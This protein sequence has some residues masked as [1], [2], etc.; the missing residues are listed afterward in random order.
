MSENRPQKKW[1]FAGVA[2]GLLF[3]WLALRQAD[4]ATAINELSNVHPGWVA[5]VAAC[6]MIFIAI[7]ALRWQY[8]LHPVTH[9]SFNTLHKVIYIGTAAN[10]VVAHTGEL[11][12][13]TII[14]RRQDVSSS[15]VLTSIGLERIMD[16][17]ALLILTSIALIIDP[18]VSPILWSAGLISLAMIVVGLTVVVILLNPDARYFD[19]VRCLLNVLPTRLLG[20]LNAQIRRGQS[21]VSTIR[22]PKSVALLILTSLFQWFWIVASIWACLQA[23]GTTIPLSGAIAVFV[24]TIIGLTL[25]SSPAQLGTIQ[26]SFVFGL[27][28]VGVA[29]APAIAASLVYTFSIN[30]IMMLIGGMCW[31]SGNWFH[32]RVIR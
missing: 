21:G 20:W 31:F 10:L 23:T 26:L 17:V 2:V 1:M 32:R 18:R 6:G 11:L 5:V 25:P 30:L 7:K 28:L 16:F 14:A 12:R 8:I 3:L 27:E 9:E 22:S 13:T 29:A 4:W 24:L 15:A 19:G